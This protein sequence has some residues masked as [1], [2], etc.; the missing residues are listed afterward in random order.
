[1]QLRLK[2]V[3][4]DVSTEFVCTKDIGLAEHKLRNIAKC[5]NRMKKTGLD[6]TPDN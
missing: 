6:L 2:L 3:I 1:M 5:S 4:Q